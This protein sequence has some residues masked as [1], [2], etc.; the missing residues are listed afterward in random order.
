MSNSIV[1]VKPIIYYPRKAEVGKTYLMT[2][3]LQPEDSYDWQNSWHYEKEEY[4]VSCAVE[5]DLFESKS[6]GAPVVVIH[7]FGGS[8]GAAKFMLTAGIEAKYGKIEVALINAWGVTFR[9]LEVDNIELVTS[10]ISDSR[11][12]Y[13]PP[14]PAVKIPAF[15]PKTEPEIK[16]NLPKVFIS[17]SHDSRKHNDR[18][19]ALAD[20][21]RKEGVDCNIDQYEQSPPKGWHLWMLEQIKRSDFVLVMCTKE[22]QRRFLADESYG[23]GRWLTWEGGVIIQSIYRIGANNTK[24]IPVLFSDNDSRFI[25]TL[26]RNITEYVV[27]LQH[28]DGYESLYRRLTGQLLTQRSDLGKIVKFSLLSRER[29]QFFSVKEPYNLPQKTYKKF[30]GR[31]VEIKKL[32]R[33]ISPDYRQHITEVRGIGGIGKTAL[34]IEAAYRCLEAKRNLDPTSDRKKIPTFDAIIFTSSKAT[35]LVGSKFMARPEKEST[36]LDIFRVIAETLNEPIINQVSENKQ[37]EQVRAVLAKK[38]VLL[39][40]DNIETL[41]ETQRKK[42]VSFLHN[43]PYPTQVIITTRESLG[44]NTN[45]IS[46]LSEKESER[47]IKVQAE[48]KGVS[49]KTEQVTQIYQRFGG[50]PIAL[51]YAVAQ[52]AAGYSLEDILQPQSSLTENIGKFCFD[53]SVIRLRDTS[54]YKL[55]IAMTFFNS[56]P[57]RNALSR[58]AG[59]VDGSEEVREG[60][61]QLT[62][63]SLIADEEDRYTMLSITREYVLGE[64]DKYVDPNFKIEARERWLN[65]YVEF[66]KIYGGED[67]ENWRAKYDRLEE[68]WVNIEL[69]LNWYEAQEDWEKVLEFWEQIDG[70]VDLNRYWEKRYY[71]WNRICAKTDRIEIKIKALSEKGWTSILMGIEYHEEAEKWLNQAW[72]MRKVT[73]YVLIQK[74]AEL[75]SRKN[76]IITVQADVANHLA[77]L[78]KGRKNYTKAQ[79]WLAEEEKI[80]QISQSLPKREQTRHQ[81]QNLYYQA[82]INQIL[83]ERS[84]A[85]EQFQT[86]LELCEQVKWDRFFNYT[87]NNLADIL[88][89]ELD[90]EQA[91]NILRR[92]LSVAETMKEIRRIALY[93][94]SYARLHYQLAKQAKQEQLNEELISYHLI[95]SQDYIRKAQE[96][97]QKEWM[98]IEVEQITEL[99]VSIEDNFS[100]YL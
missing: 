4:P 55:L 3:D 99:I 27:S 35:T 28:P 90:L 70:Y 49:F 57:C 8:Y 72:E 54:A 19:L 89:E 16:N 48:A 25:P 94:F 9:I 65:W 79:K 74:D 14:T 31:S 33:C 21:L 40:I 34:V 5:S 10:L 41:N 42:V 12:V 32:I 67:W 6:I 1:S 30:I 78:E 76:K 53:S 29:Q 45:N 66:T 7:C 97:F 50:T 98:I 15:T 2:I 22:Y 80:L 81:I 24:F 36:L 82:E 37:I 63:L 38:S 17:Y 88:I 83:G 20:Q 92:G 52:R 58:V 26:F 73:S 13:L 43:V 47:L 87:Q 68:E 95:R 84:L 86:V 75:E 77:I 91:E 59:L 93:H 96:V 51:I 56:S 71:W 62:R 100:D 60:L 39:I 69:V 64:L 18:V 61:A 46:S 11:T 85:K 44:F 23:K